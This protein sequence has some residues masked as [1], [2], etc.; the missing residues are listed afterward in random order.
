M[1]LEGASALVLPIGRCPIERGL[2]LSFRLLCGRLFFPVQLAQIAIDAGW[3]TGELFGNLVDS[4]KSKWGFILACIGS[5]VG[6]GNIWLFP[7]RVSKYGGATFLIPYFI[8]VVLIGSTGVIG[9]MAFGRAAGMGPIGAFGKAAEMRTGSKKL[10]ETV[11]LLPVLGSLALA[12]GYSVVVGWIFKY[13]FGS[14]TGSVLANDG[15]DALGG[16]FG[17]TAS[18][19]GNNFWRVIGM[20]VTLVIMALGVG[21]GIEKANKVMMPLFFFLFIGLGIW[22][23]C[24]APPTATGISSCWTPGALPD[25]APGRLVLSHRQ[26]CLLRR[27]RA[28]PDRGRGAGR[29]RLKPAPRQA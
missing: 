28:G 13:P 8:F 9:E 26:V 23:R 11:G 5:A 4:F 29:D 19:W 6:M 22:R 1:P 20:A 15:L 10:G 14:F 21:G 27:D 25:K 7:A 17:G 16:L 3:G 12:I 24:P 18:A 2:F